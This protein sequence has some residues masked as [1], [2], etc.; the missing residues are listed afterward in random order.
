MCNNLYIGTRTTGNDTI[1]VSRPD[2]RPRNATEEHGIAW[3]NWGTRGEGLE[4]PR[5]RVDFGM[6]IMRI[7][8]CNPS[9]ADSPAK[10]EQ[11]S[12]EEAIMG[13]YFPRGEYTDKASFEANGPR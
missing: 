2:D 8:A 3:L 11:P 10:I 4:D 9:W 1:V 7:M 5:N 12:T 6:L 13:P